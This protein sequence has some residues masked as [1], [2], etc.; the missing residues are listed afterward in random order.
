[1]IVY[2]DRKNHANLPFLDETSYYRGNVFFDAMPCDCCGKVLIEMANPVTV[3]TRFND[4][5]FYQQGKLNA[6]EFNITDQ[7]EFVDGQMICLD[8]EGK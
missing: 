3:E 1:M 5:A 7:Y 6:A 8:C 2:T 4:L